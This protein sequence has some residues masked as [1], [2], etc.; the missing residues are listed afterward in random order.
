MSM[1]TA[2]ASA[3]EG[4][5]CPRVYQ[6]IAPRSA[7]P[8]VTWQPIG[9]KTLRAVDNTPLDK[10]NTLMQINVWADKSSDARDLIRQIEDD[11]C[12]SAP[13]SPSRRARRW[14]TYEEDTKLY[15]ALQRFSIYA[16]RT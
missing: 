4:V 10:R 2:L 7:A 6:V 14:P 5:R 9:G 13:S 8:Y 1:E 12:A 15:G 3:A 16:A 11:L